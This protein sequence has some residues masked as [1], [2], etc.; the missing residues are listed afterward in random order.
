[1]TT[2]LACSSTHPPSFLLFFKY[3]PSNDDDDVDETSSFKTGF[4]GRAES[5]GKRLL[6]PFL[7]CDVAEKE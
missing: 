3:L 6:L 4:A 2:T 1:M 5:A 7:Q